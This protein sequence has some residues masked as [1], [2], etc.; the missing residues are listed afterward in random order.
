[1]IPMDEWITMFLSG[2]FG[3][4]TEHLVSYWPWRNRANV[5][6]LTFEEMKHDLAGSVRQIARLMDVELSA[7]EFTLVVEKSSFQYMKQIDHKFVPQHPFPFNRMGKPVMIRKGERGAA[8]ELLTREQQAQ[9][10]H[11]MRAELQ[12]R[13]CDFPYNAAFSVHAGTSAPFESA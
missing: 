8:S 11:Q 10:D 1:M 13:A 2:N 3:S 5:P 12:Q 9:I 7:E 6:V 4:W